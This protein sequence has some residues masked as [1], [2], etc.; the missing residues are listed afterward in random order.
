DFVE[1]VPEENKLILSNG[2][3]SYY[4]LVFATGT[5]T[6]YFGMEIVKKYAIPMKTINDAVSMRNT[7]L[8]RMEKA[9]ITDDPEEKK[10]LLTIVVAG[11]GP[12]RKST[13]LNSSH[14]K[15]SYAVFCLNIERN[16]R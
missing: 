15:I 4:L 13:H 8:Q 9:T 6:N 10:R 3:L 5:E 16:I 1:V 7:L 12:D 14:V 2:E 11:A